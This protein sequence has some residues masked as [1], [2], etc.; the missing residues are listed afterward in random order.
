MFMKAFAILL[1]ALGAALSGQARAETL[2]LD[3][4]GGWGALHQYHNVPTSDPATTVTMY[5]GAKSMSL[6]FND[7]VSDQ[8]TGPYYGSGVGTVLT[9]PNGVQ[10]FLTIDERTRRACTYSG[11]GQHCSTIWTL[12]DGTLDRPNAPIAQIAVPEVVGLDS[13]SAIAA[14]EAIGLVATPQY[15]DD[16]TDAND[17]VIAVNPD[18]DTLVDP[19][20]EVV[21]L[22]AL[23]PLPP[24]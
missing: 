1:L 7:N 21:V 14:I 19:G 5:I 24:V 16:S 8:F 2:T 3:T 10:I 4:T 12:V 15:V 18:V 17:T 20:S 22:I 9:D 13:A 6:W 11:R 23:A